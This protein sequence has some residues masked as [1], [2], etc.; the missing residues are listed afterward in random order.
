[1]LEITLKVR[2]ASCDGTGAYR[3]PADPDGKPCW[4]CEGKGWRITTMTAPNPK[5]AKAYQAEK[6]QRKQG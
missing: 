1:M 6:R 5:W 2:C 3:S 4:T